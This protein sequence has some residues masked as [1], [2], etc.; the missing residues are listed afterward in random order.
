M[1]SNEGTQV[2]LGELLL[3]LSLRFSNSFICGRNN[4]VLNKCFSWFE[5]VTRTN[6]DTVSVRDLQKLSL[7]TSV[8]IPIDN[9]GRSLVLVFWNHRETN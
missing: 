8:I 1:E 2:S 9:K 7:P 4:P 3:R 5:V 6:P